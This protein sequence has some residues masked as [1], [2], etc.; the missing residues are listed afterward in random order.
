MQ[1]IYTGIGKKYNKKMPQEKQ[2]FIDLRFEANS[3]AK[4]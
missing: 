3:G 1:G 4:H 2:D